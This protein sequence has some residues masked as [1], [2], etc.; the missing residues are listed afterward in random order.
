MNRPSGRFTRQTSLVYEALLQDP[1][2]IP[3]I[4][5]QVFPEA[6]FIPGI[7]AQVFPRPRF[8]PVPGIRNTCIPSKVPI[9]SGDRHCLDVAN[10]GRKHPALE[11]RP[12]NRPSGGSPDRRAS[13][14]RRCFKT[15]D[16]F[17]GLTYRYSPRP[18][19]IP[20][21]D[22]RVSHQGPRFIPGI[23]IHAFPPR[24]RFIPGIDIA[25]M[26]LIPGVNTRP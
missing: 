1:G 6:L 23:E 12:V 21:I 5:V 24:S 7:N 25:W 3:G 9:H 10:S 4:N 8:I 22:L 11:N 13:F 18:L 17:R 26:W 16:L 15:R 14:T 19:F 2:F 20:G